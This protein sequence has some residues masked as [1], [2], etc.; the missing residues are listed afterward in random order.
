M[1]AGC[2][3]TG[4]YK[5]HSLHMMAHL[6][7]DSGYGTYSVEVVT[8]LLARGYDLRI[9]SP[10]MHGEVSAA[11]KGRTIGLAHLRDR[12]FVIWPCVIAPHGMMPRARITAMMTMWETTRL[13]SKNPQYKDAIALLNQAR[14]VIVP[15]SWNATVFSANGINTPIRIAPL[16]SDTRIF[17]PAPNDVSGILTFGT[18]GRIVG[19]GTRK[20]LDLVVEAFRL[21]FPREK[22]VRLRVKC[23]PS[24]PP[25]KAD[26][27]RIHICNRCLPIAD[28]KA[29]YDSLNVYVSASKSE[30]WG[31]HQ[32]EAMCCGR[33]LIGVNFGGVCE[34]FNEDNGYAVDWTMT[35]GE[36]VYETMG[37]YA[38]PNFDSL[39][40]QMRAV[41]LDRETL[42]QKI[43]LAVESAHRFT[44]QHSVDRI[45]AA[46]REFN[47][48]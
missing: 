10:A 20:G 7:T 41:Y 8:E 43:P 47:V 1:K 19:G 21:A 15:C 40:D 46:L 35:P 34:F 36:G 33:P 45:L 13:R 2:F 29:W 30:G 26:D 25:I 23:F 31:R 17:R 6:D 4:D 9:Y 48:V 16:C 24:D 39:V 44:V 11:I 3:E 27:S 5:G 42:A 18:A 14:V 37:H 12:V 22:D 38:T 32:H 28:L